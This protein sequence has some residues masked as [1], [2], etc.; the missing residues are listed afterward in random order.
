MD[1]NGSVPGS[2]AGS[3]AGAGPRV[4]RFGRFM[5]GLLQS[6]LAGLAGGAVLV[7]YVG[8]RSG[9]TRQ[10]PVRCERWDGGRLIRVGRP[11]QKRW[12]RNFTEPAPIELVRG[13]SVSRGTAVVVLGSTDSG[14]QIAAACFDRHSGYAR[15]A[16]LPNRQ[17]GETFDPAAV[18]AAAAPL[19][20]V[21]VTPEPAAR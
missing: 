5:I 10:L 3:A 7:R 13:R 20:F 8:R 16:G 19:V 21:V 9:L 2:A 14:R 12:W 18:A 11:E 15:R 17:K 6:P 4:S 1:G